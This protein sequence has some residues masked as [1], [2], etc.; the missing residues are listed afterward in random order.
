M[1]ERMKNPAR[2][3]QHRAGRQICGIRGFLQEPERSAAAWRASRTRRKVNIDWIEVGAAGLARLP[4]AARSAFDG[5]LV[6]G[7]FGKRGIEGMLHAIRFAR[8]EQGPVFRHLPGHA[9]HGD[10]VRPQCLRAGRRRFHR[11]RSRHAAP[12]HLQ[13]ARVERRRR[14]GRHHAAGRVSCQSGRRKFRRA[15][16]MDAQRSASAT[17]IATNSIANLKTDSDR[18]RPAAHRPD[19]GRRLR[20]DLRA[21]RSSLV[22]GLPVPSRIQ[23]EAA[24]AA[25][26]VHGVSRRRTEASRTEDR[27]A[28]TEVA[29][30]LSH[31]Q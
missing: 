18:T 31:A 3:G 27:T 9:D 29:P 2:R 17:A 16:P 1:L 14:T 8:E 21:C 28:R 10:R 15:R 5:I 24:G 23:I 22:S 4:R 30:E 12:R 7:G 20:R 19:A 25:S 26:A 11:V 6:P 13:V